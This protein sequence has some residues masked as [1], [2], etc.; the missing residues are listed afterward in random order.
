[1]NFDAGNIT[2]IAAIIA[3]VLV[4]IINN[5]HQRSLRKLELD[6]E[7][8]TMKLDS[9][10]TDKKEAFLNFLINAGKVGTDEAQHEP[11]MDFYGYTQVAILFASE[12][13]QK[14]ISDFSSDIMQ[15]IDTKIPPERYDELKGKL[16]TV[17]ASLNKELTALQ[18]EICAKKRK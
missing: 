17:A 7:I 11:E 16:S 4:A 6:H 13:N 15:Y 2:A 3:P 5:L 10:Y 9:L 14:L 18:N 1:M 8:T 12:E